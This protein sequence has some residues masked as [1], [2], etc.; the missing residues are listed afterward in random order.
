MFHVHSVGCGLLSESVTDVS[1]V[2]F[3]QQEQHLWQ[4]DTRVG[5]WTV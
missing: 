1:F 2:Y 3:S 5:K 4:S